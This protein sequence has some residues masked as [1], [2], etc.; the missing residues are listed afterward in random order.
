M[1]WKKVRL[2]E[3]IKIKTG[4]KDVNEGNPKGKYPFFTCAKENT[5]SDEF[6]FDC[7]AILIAG[8]GVVGQTSYYKGKFEAYQRTY[9][10]T[11]F[12]N[13]YPKYLLLILEN[14][15]I[16]NLSSKVLGNTIPYI[17]KSMLENFELVLPSLIEQKKILKKM[18]SLIFEINNTIQINEKNI[19]NFDL[20]FKKIQTKKIN[21]I[22]LKKGQKIFGDIAKFKNGINFKKTSKGNPIKI[23]GV[24]DFK[25][26]FYS[27][28]DKFD[29]VFLNDSLKSNDEI[30]ENAIVFVRSHGNKNLIGRS[31]LVS[32]LKEKTTF[33]GFT[34]RARLNDKKFLPEFVTYILKS[35]D[36][37][38][39]LIKTGI[40][41]NISSLNQESLSNLKIPNSELEEQKK[42]ITIFKIIEEYKNELQSILSQKKQNL[43]KLKK[44]IINQEI[45]FIPA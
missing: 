6:S 20:F 23:L 32:N 34:I 26:N 1:T 12:K 25:S 43:K 8:N 38:N 15:L 4:K 9:V 33:S 31:M 27:E 30:I 45:K 39:Q 29:T 10:L 36:I 7:E 44:L 42:F 17:K 14:N 41:T 18:N 16:Q 3:I 40:G 22:F 35:E 24:K 5:F 28:F 2:A 21:E 13:I 11:G 19:F 37:R